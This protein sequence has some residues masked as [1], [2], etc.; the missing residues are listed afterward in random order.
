[1][2]KSKVKNKGL[3]R[4]KENM[5]KTDVRKQKVPLSIYQKGK[6]AFH[7]AKVSSNEYSK[8]MLLKRGTDRA[9]RI[10]EESRFLEG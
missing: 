2:V 4:R 7:S 10:L 5:S 6:V 9:K 3:F 1:M 8:T